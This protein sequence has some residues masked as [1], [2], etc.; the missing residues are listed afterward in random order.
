MRQLSGGCGEECDNPVCRQGK[1]LQLST[2]QAWALACHFASQGKVPHCKRLRDASAANNSEEVPSTGSDASSELS[3]G[4]LFSTIYASEPFFSKRLLIKFR[5]A[6]NA[7]DHYQLRLQVLKQMKLL[8]ADWR[9]L[10]DLVRPDQ[11]NCLTESDMRQAWSLLCDSQCSPYPVRNTTYTLAGLIAMSLKSSLP[12][13]TSLQASDTCRPTDDINLWVQALTCLFML[14]M[15]STLSGDEG[16][17]QVDGK[18]EP[19][20]ADAYLDPF[21]T[22]LSSLNLIPSSK[23]IEPITS[24]MAH[25]AAHVQD[26]RN[27]AMALQNQLVDRD[28][29]EFGESERSCNAANALQL[30]YRLATNVEMQVNQQGS[31][32]DRLCS[33]LDP[34]QEWRKWRH[35]KLPT[36]STSTHSV[37]S[38]QRMSIHGRPFS[39]HRQWLRIGMAASFGIFGVEFSPFPFLNTPFLLT[40]AFK[41]KVVKIDSL[42]RMS[43]AYEDACVNHTL[44]T[45]ARHLLPWASPVLKEIESKVRDV[46]GPY[47]VLNVRRTHLLEDTLRQIRK[48]WGDRLKPLKIRFVKGGEYGMDQGGVQKEF[49]TVA[50]AKLLDPKLGLF[51][52]DNESKTHWFAGAGTT[53]TSHNEQLYELFGLLIGLSVYNGILIP[54]HAPPVF[55]RLANMSKEL[56]YHSEHAHGQFSIQELEEGWPAL[57]RGLKALRDWDSEETGMSVED[58]FSRDFDITYH[59]ASGHSIDFPLCEGGSSIPVTEDNRLE[60][61]DAYC[62]HFMFIS[63]KDRFLAVRRGIRAILQGEIPW[64]ICEWQDL[65]TIICGQHS[66]SDDDALDL[67]ELHASAE[68]DDGYHLEHPTIKAF[69]NVVHDLTP[70][71]KRK[72]LNFVTASDRIPIG[73]LKE[74][75]FIVQRNGPDSD[76]LPTAL[77]CFSRLLLPD[78]TGHPLAFPTFGLS[79]GL[80][81]K[82]EHIDGLPGFIAEDKTPSLNEQHKSHGRVKARVYD[83][84]K[85]CVYCKSDVTA[86]GRAGA[87][88]ELRDAQT[89][90]V[91]WSVTAKGWSDMTIVGH[92]MEIKLSTSATIFQFLYRNNVYRWRLLTRSKKLSRPQYHL[93]CHILASSSSQLI[94]TIDCNMTNL[95]ISAFPIATT[96]LSTN[97]DEPADT[98]GTLPAHPFTTFLIFSGLCALDHISSVIHSLG[99]GDEALRMITDPEFSRGAMQDPPLTSAQEVHNLVPH[100]LTSNNYHPSLP[101]ISS[102]HEETD[103]IAFTDNYPYNYDDADSY[104][105]SYSLRSG[106]QIDHLLGE[107]S[108]QDVGDTEQCQLDRMEI[109]SQDP[110]S[111]RNDVDHRLVLDCLDR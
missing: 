57:A 36:S 50:L 33:T 26:F 108:F 66:G 104:R 46:T 97:T 5:Y 102:D 41:S 65:E 39:R 19:E 71:Q 59:D 13:I 35:A 79:P 49:M 77:T 48:K 32:H 61:I 107:N 11:E 109:R 43:R 84:S 12:S 68:Y 9:T 22:L 15:M 64:D 52:L 80:T 74:L 21:A 78:S 70:S 25:V 93:E 92:D 83:T 56:L 1:A 98:F 40:T 105:L 8:L 90:A 91:V 75:T 111:T 82:L 17:V 2:S 62:R 3:G 7:E 16:T 88:A 81:Y 30:L 4:N 23:P 55:Y 96:T 20:L 72:L 101:F 86:E 51:C 103:S 45:H 44:V 94:C 24:L 31:L 27:V 87:L 29:K 63:I 47:L 99:G 110:E 95:H 54:F 14:P 37:V 53:L 69:W 76:R 106:L 58:V 6:P 73:G 28:C 67:A 60:Y 10:G 100:T 18:L 89:D 42:A 85:N 34:K 38:P